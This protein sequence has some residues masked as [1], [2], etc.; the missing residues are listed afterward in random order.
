MRVN[1]WLLLLLLLALDGCQMRE[2]YPVSFS[3]GGDVRRIVG[4]SW[5]QENGI[6]NKHSG[7]TGTE[8]PII[9]TVVLPSG[10][11]FS[12]YSRATFATQ[13]GGKLV[14]LTLTPH[15]KRLTFH[16]ALEIIESLAK[17]MK[18]DKDLKLRN[19][20]KQW[21]DKPPN[22]KDVF[23]RSMFVVPEEDVKLFIEIKSHI[24]DPTWYI[25]LEFTLSSAFKRAGKGT[26]KAEKEGRKGEGRKGEAEKGT[27][28]NGTAACLS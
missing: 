17:D 14:E 23:D 22:R 11:Q 20:I 24:D 13:R 1:Y 28:P 10:R 4:A 12:T 19:A 26:E 15:K 2:P 3:L 5:N 25:S 8:A 21:R 18:I 6:L 7:W 16:E 27:G 9:A